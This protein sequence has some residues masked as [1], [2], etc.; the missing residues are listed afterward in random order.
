MAASNFHNMYFLSSTCNKSLWYNVCNF[1]GKP[2][3]MFL[4]R[5]FGQNKA[6][7]LRKISDGE[8]IRVFRSKSDNGCIEELFDRYSHLVFGVCMKYLKDIEDSKDAVMQIFENLPVILQRQKVENFSSWLYTVS[9]NHCLMILRKSHSVQSQK[10]VYFEQIQ[11]EV[12]ESQ[13]I[14]HQ[15]NKNDLNEKLPFLQSAIE[16]LNE[17]Q[18]KCIEL[19]YLHDKSY[20]EVSSLTGYTLKQVKSYIQNGKRNLRIYLESK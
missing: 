14:F 12:V 10:V 16:T 3:R 20:H 13:D 4:K 7:D 18:R 2:N 15:H 19:I 9:K 1:S 8:L 5:I 6:N 11:R 17:E